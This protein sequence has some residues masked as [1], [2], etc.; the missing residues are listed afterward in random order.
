MIYYN[1][2]TRRMVVVI[3]IIR[4]DS[5]LYYPSPSIIC[6]I[7]WGVQVTSENLR[8]AQGGTLAPLVNPI[9]ISVNFILISVK[10]NKLQYFTWKEFNEY[11]P[12]YRAYLCAPVRCAH[13]TNSTN[14]CPTY[15]ARGYPC[16]WSK[17][18]FSQC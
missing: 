7:M 4:I 9:F 8:I 1:H 11:M 12:T 17:P 6:K 18:H 16:P 3:I 2:R 5:R 13:E 10:T 15:S 14:I